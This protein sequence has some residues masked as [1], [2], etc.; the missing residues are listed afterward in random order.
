LRIRREEELPVFEKLG[1]VLNRAITLGKVAD[2]HEARGQ[3]DEALRIRRE[4][5]LP[6]FEK[7]GNVRE[8]LVGRAN[9]ALI[10]LARNQPGDRETAADLLRWAR[11]QAEEL[12][13]PEASQIQAIQRQW[14]LDE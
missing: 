6:V 11:A 14:K 12:Q 10:H 3:L 7:L 13:I 5:A 1:D 9:L 2:I 8:L 4:D